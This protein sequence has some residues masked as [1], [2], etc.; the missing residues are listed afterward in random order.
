MS[1]GQTEELTSLSIKQ[2]C[3]QYRNGESDPVRVTEA[4]LTSISKKNA[5]LN[6]FINTTS[7]H[8]LQAAQASAQ[9]WQSGRALSPIDGVPIAIKDNI[10]LSGFETTN[11]CKFGPVAQQDAYVVQ[12]LKAAGAIILGKLNQHELALGTT[13]NNPHFG[14]SNN[15]VGI[16]ITPGGS[17]GGSGVAVAAGLAAA[18]LGTD[19]MGSVRIPASYCGCFGIKPTF[20]AVSNQGVSPLAFSLDHVGPLTRTAEDLELM[21]YA[22]TNESLDLTEFSIEGLRVGRVKQIEEADI[23]IDVLNSYH[24]FLRRL[25]DLGANLVDVSWPE[26]N[27][28]QARLAGLLVSE[29]DAAE[30]YADD[31]AF[32]P[33]RFS[34]EI[35]AMISYGRDAKPEKIKIARNI[36]AKAGESVNA[37]FKTVDVIAA[38]ASPIP[39]FK[40]STPAPANQADFTA[41]ANFA[42]C[43][44]ISIP[45]GKNKNELP[46]G[47][48]LMAAKGRDI[49][50][51]RLVQAINIS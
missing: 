49:G 48:Q 47:V 40:F 27:M 32:R 35:R 28:T 4:Y 37:S 44:A 46:L 13:T 16:G 42:G 22:M 1:G 41:P 38:P 43:P 45:E 2:L 11:G 10:D 15:P 33:E 39:A 14:P 34:P 31:L 12:R 6:A 26:L 23:Q 25:S 20:G 30:A 21:L 5:A 8:A 18:S 7:E 29:V 50:L 19:T 24:N 51:I 3:H 9:R 17:S 36:I